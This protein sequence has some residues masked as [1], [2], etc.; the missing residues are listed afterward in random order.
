MT[1]SVG[2]KEP[3]KQFLVKNHEDNARIDLKHSCTGA[4]SQ[5]EY[6]DALFART[7]DMVDCLTMMI[8]SSMML[9][10]RTLTCP[11]AKSIT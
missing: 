6:V 7:Q 10:M 4:S 11:S 3:H 9:M 2:K 1:F 8:I 5:V